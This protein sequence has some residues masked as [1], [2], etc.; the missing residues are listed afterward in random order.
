MTPSGL[1]FHGVWNWRAHGFGGPAA[2]FGAS[3]LQLQKATLG[4]AS[5]LSNDPVWT[6]VYV[7]VALKKIAPLYS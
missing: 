5:R 1:N 2:A 4:T 6:S 7:V 3:F